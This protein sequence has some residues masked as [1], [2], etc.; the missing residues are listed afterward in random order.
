MKRSGRDMNVILEMWTPPE[1]DL[2]ATILKERRWVEKS[3]AYLQGLIPNRV[4]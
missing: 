1:E 3:V 4:K 2:E